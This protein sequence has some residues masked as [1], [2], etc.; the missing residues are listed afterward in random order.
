MLIEYKDFNRAEEIISR[1]YAG[2]WEDIAGVIESMPLHVKASDQAGRQGTAIFDAVGTNAYLK[3]ILEG[4]S[5]GSQIPIP[6]RYNFLGK[7]VDFGKA[8][9]VLEVQFS[10]YPFL[11]NNLVRSELF[12]KA[13]VAL[14]DRPMGLLIVITKSGMFPASQSTLYHEQAVRQVT[15]LA[16]NDVFDVPIRLVGLFEAPDVSV[17]AVWTEYENP[18]YS[19]T[20]VNRERRSLLISR[21]PKRFILT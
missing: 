18:R 11:L 8:G 2:Q 5:W 4:L 10:N 15:A 6:G 9:V 21:R 16:E 1:E 13:E 3:G 12:Y 17:D 19:R 7:D 14:P 20:V